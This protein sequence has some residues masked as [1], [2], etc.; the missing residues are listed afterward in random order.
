MAQ[1]IERCRRE[2]P[3][4]RKGLIPLGQI[5]VAGDDGGGRFVALGDQLVQILVGG[6][7]QGFE[8][9]VVDD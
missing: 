8:A 7:A 3:I 1:S 2:Q 5:E 9:E 4:G 6:R